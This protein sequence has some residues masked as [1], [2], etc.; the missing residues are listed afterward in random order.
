MDAG[1]PSKFHGGDRKLWLI[2][3]DLAAHHQ[4]R[5]HL[6][7]RNPLFEPPR[8]RDKQI[9]QFFPQSPMLLE[10]EQNGN[11]A[12]LLVDDVPDSGHASSSFR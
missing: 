4:A 2:Y 7:E 12:T 11:P 8:P 9:L 6:S 5:P 10:V 3:W 1:A